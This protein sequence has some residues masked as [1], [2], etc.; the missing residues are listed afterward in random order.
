MPPP[1][2][3]PL[4]LQLARTAKLVSRAFDDSLAAVGGSV[5]VWS[6]LIA[7]KSQRLV[8]NQR[9]LADALGIQG[10][11]LSH[12]LTALETEGLVTRRRD[13]HNR[14]VHLVELTD[15]GEA[16]FHRLRAAAVAFDQRLRTG[17]GEQEIHTLEQ[18]LGRLRDNVTDQR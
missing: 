5:P 18:L 4:G 8:A 9:R 11:T 16:L 2:R 15:R 7:L 10:A 6:I 1:A 17:F 14:R 3:P 12:H 13:P